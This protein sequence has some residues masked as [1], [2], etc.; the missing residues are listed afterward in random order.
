[1]VAKLPHHSPPICGSALKATGRIIGPALVTFLEFCFTKPG[2]L[3]VDEIF[4]ESFTL[5]YHLRFTM[6]RVYFYQCESAPFTEGECT[7]YGGPFDT[8]EVFAGLFN[9]QVFA[10]FCGAGGQQEA[11][12]L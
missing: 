3:L 4:L 5:L 6:N 9:W 1:M 12:R 11:S 8:L 7:P 2:K 10:C